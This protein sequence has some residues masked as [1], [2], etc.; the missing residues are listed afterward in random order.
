[1]IAPA[2]CARLGDAAT[3]RYS[4]L[5]DRHDGVAGICW[6]A[7][8][9]DHPSHWYRDSE[10]IVSIA[11]RAETAVHGAA[12]QPEPEWV[13]IEAGQCIVPGPLVPHR[14]RTNETSGYTCLYFFLN[15][16]QAA[17]ANGQPRESF[18]RD[19]MAAPA[20][21]VAPGTPLVSG[22]RLADLELGVGGWHQLVDGPDWSVAVA[23]LGEETSSR[24]HKF[25]WVVRGRVRCGGGSGGAHRNSH[26]ASQGQ[27]V[28]ASGAALADWRLAPAVEDGEEPPVVLL[29]GP[30]ATAGTST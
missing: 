27:L 10:C 5:Y 22:T 29:V 18:T 4:R 13:P 19:D 16:P 12:A 3:L 25:G 14:T 11:G 17:V 15:G 26:V 30:K 28:G 7:P 2:D 23:V 21:V 24:R 20:A 1:M 6:Q 8:G 9:F